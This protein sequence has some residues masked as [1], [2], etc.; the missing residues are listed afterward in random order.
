VSQELKVAEVMEKK[1]LTIDLDGRVSQAA[2]VMANKGVSCLVVVKDRIAVGIVTERDL[3]TK[4]LVDSMDP[5]KVVVRDIMSTPLI[6][7][8]PDATVEAAAKLMVEYAIRKV[9]VI[10]SQGGLAGIITGGDL[11]RTLAKQKSYSDLTLNAIARVKDGPKDG[12]Y[13]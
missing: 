2:K 5:A 10:D 9:V 6:T 12:P 3:V 8:S 7:I 4:V 11:A 13:Q 1:V